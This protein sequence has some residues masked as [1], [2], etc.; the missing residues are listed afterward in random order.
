MTLASDLLMKK[1]ILLIGSYFSPEQTGIGKY[2]GEM[3]MWLAGQG[4]DCTVITTS[5]WYPHWKVQTP[6]TNKRYLKEVVKTPVNNITI[7]RCPQYIPTI[8]NGKKRLIQELSFN[9]SSFINLIWILSKKKFDYVIAVVPPFHI[10]LHAI[11]YK[12]LRGAKF[13]YHVQDLQ[14]EA[15][16]DLK[17]IKSGK[18]LN[19]LFSMEKY[20]LEKADVVSSISNGMI[21]R[22]QEK[23]N[24]EVV[25]FPN[26]V[27][28]NYFYPL[29]NQEELKQQFGYQPS[30][31]IILYSGAIGEKQ[32]LEMLVNS[33]K[34]LELH[35]ELKFIICGS[36]PYKEKLM[37]IATEKNLQNIHFIPL[38]PYE[39]FNEFLN[40]ADIHIVLQKK[41]ASD[42]VMPSKLSTI[43]SVGGLAL[44]TAAPGSS[45]Y[46]DVRKNQ[47]G[48]LVEPE[49]Q[50]ELDKALLEIVSTDHSETCKNARRYAEEFLAISNVLSRYINHID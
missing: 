25:F 1:R 24:K 41:D 43:L 50:K 5:P 38:Q 31:K 42:L 3:I 46:E 17:M 14:I 28:I 4:Y 35:T 23:T 2:S 15:A 36:G 6:Y 8:P 10:G 40:M 44:I 45:L 11:L 29:K 49:N 48:I 13:L 32:G 22:I 39:K 47:I 12:K 26:W 19:T 16:R 9:V 18:L 33:A 37:Q 34:T 30:D 7:Y 27:D 20:I 21:K